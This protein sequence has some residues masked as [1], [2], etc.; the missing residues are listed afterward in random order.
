MSKEDNEFQDEKTAFKL[1]QYYCM[2]GQATYEDFQTR[3]TALKLIANRLDAVRNLEQD[4]KRLETL[5][6]SYEAVPVSSEDV[7][8]DFSNF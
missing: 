7:S 3:I 8:S 6:G 5:L 2:Q 1:I 4:V